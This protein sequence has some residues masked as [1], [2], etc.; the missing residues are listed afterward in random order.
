MSAWKWPGRLVGWMV[1]FGI[2]TAAVDAD[3][4]AVGLVRQRLLACGL[5]DVTVARHAEQLA[6]T[7]AFSRQM[8]HT[9]AL[10]LVALGIEDV[11]GDCDEI[12]VVARRD[13]RP[14]LQFRT[15]PDGFADFAELN[16]SPECRAEA[17]ELWEHA[18][19]ATG[20]SPSASRAETTS[21]SPQAAPTQS[22]F[23]T[24]LA[25][26]VVA[27][28]LENVEVRA[29]DSGH[30][31]IEYENRTYR[32][33]AEA[34]GTVAGI[35][36]QHCPALTTLQLTAK[37]DAVPVITVPPQAWEFEQLRGQPAAV[38]LDLIEPGE[39]APPGAVVASSGLLNESF[40]RTD[41]SFRP[42][43][44]YEIGNELRPMMT[45]WL[46]LPQ[47]TTTLGPGWRA[48]LGGKLHLDNPG[49]EL[50]RMLLTK[51]GRSWG[52]Q[53]LWTA[54]VGRFDTRLRGVFG[55]AQWELGEGRAGM[56]LARLGRDH[57]DLEIPMWLGYY[58]HEFGN[59]GL[60]VRATAGQ[61]AD[62]M[63]PTG[64]VTLDR[65]FGES[66]ISTALTVDSPVREGIVRV[67]MPFGPR[68]GADPRGLRLRPADYLRLDYFTDKGSPGTEML[69]GDH[70]LRAFRDEL[71]SPYLAANPGRLRGGHR[72]M[73]E[74]TWPCGP[75]HE[76]TS[77]LIRIPTADVI[78]DGSYRVGA[79]FLDA[80]HARG[81]HEGQ[82]DMIPTFVNIGF[83]PN[84]ELGF[85]LTV[86]P[87]LEPARFPRWDY[88]T[89]RSL[90]AHY[91]LWPQHGSLPAVAIGAQDIQVRDVHS[92]A[93]GRVEYI[94]AI[95]QVG[96]LRMH[97]GR[98]TKRL[99]G[100]FGGAEYR[101]SPRLV[102]IGEH[103]TD[104][105]NYGL[106]MAPSRSWR[107][108]VTLT[109][110][111]EIGGALSYTGLFP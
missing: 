65:R 92:E 74:Q 101:L 36:A 31:A 32:S 15:S 107:A 54:S 13:G 77:G 68:R 34:L 27:A 55:E 63:D 35:A 83:L 39:T 50:E 51:T 10:A 75:S 46:V 6:V 67:T 1:L 19:A 100:L 9:I 71:T 97:L 70:D 64:M 88:S 28:G 78:P 96:N 56:R 90:F 69:Y 57:W 8:S 105:F 44:E 99:S 106:R 66:T 7:Y 14:I 33:D 79:S 104:W 85:R 102:V 45:D 47:L 103:D 29:L 81:A 24:D 42:A 73:P 62:Y 87:D 108:D 91:R 93:I 72:S 17:R 38:P 48:S 30:V 82:G 12:S 37:R 80:A 26:A 76:G 61:F 16:T 111:R 94:V 43:V 95:E 18:A 23:V 84:L 4:G 5:Q 109:D 53:L 58:E 52:N 49:A 20:A 21:H 60:T 40:G 2:I 22:G 3:D 89:D 41:L 59:L 110:S 98:G 86:F 11:I 25:Q